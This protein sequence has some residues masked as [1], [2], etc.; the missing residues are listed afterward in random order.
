MRWK[1]P[2]AQRFSREMEMCFDLGQRSC[3]EGSN[4]LMVLYTTVA[5]TNI[6]NNNIVAFRHLRQRLFSLTE[7]RC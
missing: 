5:S 6:N 2:Q 4:E 1:C 3:G 7:T